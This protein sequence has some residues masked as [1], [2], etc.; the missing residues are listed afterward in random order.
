MLCS[1]EDNSVVISTRPV[2]SAVGDLRVVLLLS[3]ND[4]IDTTRTFEYR[5]N[6]NF[7]DIAPRNHLTA[8]VPLIIIII[9]DIFKVA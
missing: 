2:N 1:T 9:I 7:T 4:R 8:Y 5:S 6:P 3:S